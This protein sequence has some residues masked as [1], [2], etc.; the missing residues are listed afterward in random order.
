[1][2]SEERNDKRALASATKA[3]HPLRLLCCMA[4]YLPGRTGFKAPVGV[5]PI[6]PRSVSVAGS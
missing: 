6:C 2:G 1:M 4:F 5:C 3:A